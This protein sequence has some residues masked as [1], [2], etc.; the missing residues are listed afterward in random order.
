MQPINLHNNKFQFIALRWLIYSALFACGSFLFHLWLPL[1]WT[2]STAPNL[3]NISHQTTKA[4]AE[5]LWIFP[6]HV[7]VSFLVLFL[8]SFDLYPQNI[9]GCTP[10]GL[11]SKLS[12]PIPNEASQLYQPINAQWMEIEILQ[13]QMKQITLIFILNTI[14][15]EPI[16]K[17]WNKSKNSYLLVV[18]PFSFCNLGYLSITSS[19]I[20]SKT[21]NVIEIVDIY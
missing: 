11:M 19:H 7:F 8:V 17:F 4:P 6:N 2:E 1:C 3:F 13:L 18:K 5:C 12:L 9:S 16:L 10:T 21:I 20:S 15:S 14:C